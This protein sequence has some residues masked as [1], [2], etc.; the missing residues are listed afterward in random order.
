MYE[1]LYWNF[2][3]I[4]LNTGSY[5]EDQIRSDMEFASQLEEAINNDSNE[6]LLLGL[7]PSSADVHDLL[8]EA[9]KENCTK[10]FTWYRA[11]Q[12]LRSK[13]KSVETSA[14]RNARR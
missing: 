12:P 1:L 10:F 14:E 4:L 11:Y 7:Q 13:I 9:L 3:L 2:L 5:I 8:G 6:E